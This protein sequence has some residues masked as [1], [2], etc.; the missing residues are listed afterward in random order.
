MF[1]HA[2]LRKCVAFVGYVDARGQKHV[3]GTAFFVVRHSH[4][5]ES[6]Y[7]Y[8]VT[9]RHVIDDIREGKVSN[10]EIDQTKVCLRLNFNDGK[11]RWRSMNINKWLPHPDESQCVDVAV[12]RYDLLDEDYDHVPYPFNNMDF[13]TYSRSIINVNDYIGVGDEIAM[14]G[15]FW[16]HSGK[17]RAIPIVRSGNVAAIADKNELVSTELGDMEAHL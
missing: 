8:A 7:C 17:N 5:F 16:P 1:M 2:T 11:A 9:A 12:C 13:E 3:Y 15:L 6:S 10:K 4:D 14:P